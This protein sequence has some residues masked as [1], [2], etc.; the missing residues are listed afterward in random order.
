M[1]P[2]R[3]RTTLFVAVVTAAALGLTACGGSSGGPSRAST[4]P[5][6]V[7]TY[8]DQNGVNLALQA[9]RDDAAAG[10]TP[11]VGYAAKQSGG[12]FKVVGDAIE[13][14][15]YGIAV[16]KDDSGLRDAMAAAL[17]KIMNDGTYKTILDKWG[18]EATTLDKPG[19]NGAT[20]SP[21]PVPTADPKSL[22]PAKYAGGTVKV[23]SDAAYAPVES[24]AK[25]G[26]TI[27]GIDP[28]IAAA[29]GKVLGVTFK[30]TNVTFNAII[31]ALAAGR[32]DIAM[33]A[34]TDNTDREQQLDFID[35]LS[36]GSS[37][38][39]RA[40]DDKGITGFNSTL[41][42]HSV[43]AERGTIQVTQ[44]KAIKC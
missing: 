35:Y 20:G 39:V 6:T 8:P 27:I 2:T 43:A 13:T 1:Q 36:V 21:T 30:F 26:K 12:A 32:Y 31:P 14:A 18:V 4:K 44:V 3:V 42:G 10:D 29:I 22:V 24:V 9:S 15:P 7:D 37:I 38:M 23:A 25:D 28:D 34:M 17:A 40:S 19:I 11:V 16:P 5:P 33:S 41:C